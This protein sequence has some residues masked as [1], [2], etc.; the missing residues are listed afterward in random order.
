MTAAHPAASD[1]GADA[2]RWRLT[3]LAAAPEPEE[4]QLSDHSSAANLKF[5]AAT[6][7]IP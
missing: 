7:V 6:R 3:I 1:Q 5:P 4:P 2:A